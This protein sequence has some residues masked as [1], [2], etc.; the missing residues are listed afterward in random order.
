MSIHFNAYFTRAKI[1]LSS[2]HHEMLLNTSTKTVGRISI[3]NS[4]FKNLDLIPGFSPKIAAHIPKI[5][6][7]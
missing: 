7:K 4:K 5:S 3:L 6:K 2:N 1:I